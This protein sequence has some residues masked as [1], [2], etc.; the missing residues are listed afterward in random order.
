MPKQLKEYKLFFETTPKNFP[1]SSLLKASLT[2]RQ[3]FSKNCQDW[4][5]KISQIFHE[6][7]LQNFSKFTKFVLKNIQYIIK[8]KQKH[9]SKQNL[10]D[11]I[12]VHIQGTAIGYQACCWCSHFSTTARDICYPCILFSKRVAPETDDEIKHSLYF[13]P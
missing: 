1:T 3:E 8:R 6:K 12:H 10:N 4:H 2:V 11:N 13:F 9:H 5:Q 7:V